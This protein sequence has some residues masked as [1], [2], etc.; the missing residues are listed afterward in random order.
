VER[1]DVA[2]VGGGIIGL[3]TARAILGD[4]PALRLVVLE[5][6]SAIARHQSGRN[7]NVLH[8]GIYYRPGSLKAT[9]ASRGRASMVAYCAEHGIPHEVCGKVVVATREADL[10]RLDEL[11]RRAVANG[12]TIERIDP[13]RLRELEPHAVGIAAL[14]VPETGITDFGAVSATLAR[15]VEAASGTIRTGRKVER[16]LGASTVVVETDADPVAAS[17]VVNCAGLWSDRIAGTTDVRIVPFRG[18]YLELAPEK[19]SLVRNLVY[20]VP[21]PAFPFLGAHLT[22]DLHGGVHAGPNAVLALAREGYSWGRVDAREARSL[23]AFPGL[24]AIARKYWRTGAAEVARSWSK[25]LMARELS[26]LVPGITAADLTP[27]P[28][29]V[30]AQA[31]ATD[32][33][34]L[35]DFVIRQSPGRIHLVNAPSPGATA[36]LEIGRHMSGLVLEQLDR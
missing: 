10:P 36:S 25:T 18:E 11:E 16:L 32:G 35:D 12:V 14:H 19:R 29:G 24:R 21:D 27:V 28:A 22:R 1:F 13:A 6:E 2:V 5:K 30:R 9:M 3:A 26:R 4:R 33:T 17:V 7:S 15:Q 31:V 20:P 23:A 34:L 8:S